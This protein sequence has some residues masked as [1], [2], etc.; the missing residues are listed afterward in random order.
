LFVGTKINYGGW[1]NIGT[2]SLWTVPYAMVAGDLKNVSRLQV[3]GNPSSTDSILFEVKNKTGQTIFAVYEEGVRV[4]VDDG[5]K[6][7]KGGFA[8]GGFSTDKAP[9]QEYLRVT[10]DSTRISVRNLNKGTKGGFAIGGFDGVKASVYGFMNLTP[11]N[12]FIGHKSG[13]KTTTGRN[14]SVLGYESA[15]SNT[16]G[17]ENV[18]IGYRSGYSNTLGLNNIFI[19]AEAGYHNVGEIQT[20]PFYLAYGS[21]NIFLGHRAGYNNL[22][23]WTNLFIGNSAGFDNTTGT[24]NTYLGNFTGEHGLDNYANACMGAFAGRANISGDLN[25]FAGFYSGNS[26][27]SSNNTFVGAYSGANNV[28]GY[29]NTMIGFNAGLN[30]TGSGNVFIGPNAGYS[31]TGSNV[32][33]IENSTSANPLIWGDFNSNRVVINGNVASNINSRTFFVNGSAG[34]SG[35]WWNDSD[36]RLKRNIETINDALNKVLNL[37]GVN[38]EWSDPKSHDDGRR[39]GFIAQEA[40]KVIPETV[41][42]ESGTYSMQYAPVT[43]LLVEG[44]KEQ[45]RIIETQRS[46]IDSLEKKVRLLQSKLEQIELMLT[47]KD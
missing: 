5:Q 3:S 35:A 28:N 7:T 42:S 44:M 33:Y 17:S 15:F 11:Q 2:S 25:L 21:Y 27:L 40:E 1:K 9:G 34:G 39:M 29:E 43:A 6:G 30:S 36:V 37:R 16:E 18:F 32:L 8:I 38:F 47:K 19:G 45:Q 22:S 14:N 24:D 46:D 20:N 41:S 10:R 13:M 26:N 31:E 23:G 4:Y 12:Y